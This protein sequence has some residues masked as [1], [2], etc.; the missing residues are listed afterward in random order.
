MN[1]YWIAIAGL[2]LA[3]VSLGIGLALSVADDD[4]HSTGRRDGYG[5]MMSAMGYMDSEGMLESMRQVLGEEDY[6][7]MLA[8]MES[9]RA[10]TDSDSAG[11]MDGMMHEMM[12]GMMR[13]MEMMMP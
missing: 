13:E 6:Q 4:G 12:D 3:V 2:S 9:H 7:R 8:H 5:G 11:G 10:G 1:R